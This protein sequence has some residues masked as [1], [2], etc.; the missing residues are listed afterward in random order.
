MV[1]VP[2]NALRVAQKISKKSFGKCLRH[3]HNALYF[4]HKPDEGKTNGTLQSEGAVK[5]LDS[6]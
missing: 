6:H 2:L 1:R 3:S 4:R 5:A